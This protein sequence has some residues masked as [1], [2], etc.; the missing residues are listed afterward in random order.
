[1]DLHDALQTFISESRELLAEMESALLG[2]MQTD[3]RDELVNAIFRAAHTIKGSAGLFGLDPVVTFT[4]AVE[5]VLDRVRGGQL[6]VTEERV[7]LLL[8]SR[9][10]MG[11]LIDAV[12]AGQTEA[13]PETAARGIPLLERL[14]GQLQPPHTRR[15]RSCRCGR[16]GTRGP[17]AERARPRGRP[18]PPPTP[19]TCRCASASACCA[20]AWTR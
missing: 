8:E 3:E 5:S 18:P 15:T 14:R 6:P 2:V 19:G 17:G 12:A 16:C 4:H 10:H 7:A 9:D 1:M 13:D 20:T 11:A